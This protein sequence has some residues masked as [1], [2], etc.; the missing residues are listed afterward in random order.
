MNTCDFLNLCSNDEKVQ[1]KNHFKQAIVDGRVFFAL[2]DEAY[3]M[4]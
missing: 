3:V 4:V 2:G 1:A